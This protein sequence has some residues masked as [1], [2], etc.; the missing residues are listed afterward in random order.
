MAYAGDLGIF[1]LVS[2]GGGGGL[3]QMHA[4]LEALQPG[5]VILYKT[6][7]C[8]CVCV[9]TCTYMLRPN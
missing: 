6:T 4:G 1:R 2:A 9:C 5:N 3:L 8:L 7:V